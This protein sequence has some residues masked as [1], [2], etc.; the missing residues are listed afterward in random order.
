MTKVHLQKKYMERY[1]YPYETNDE[2]IREPVSAQDGISVGK[3]ILGV[4]VL[5][6]YFAL[7]SW[8]IISSVGTIL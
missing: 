5:G 1:A 4:V 2:P 7:L 8:V 3:V 6:A